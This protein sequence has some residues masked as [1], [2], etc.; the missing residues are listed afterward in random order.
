M[1]VVDRLRSATK[2]PIAL[3]MFDP[4]QAIGQLS[5]WPRRLIA[6]VAGI[7]SVFALAPFFFWPILFATFPVLVWLIDSTSLKGSTKQNLA[8]SKN[9]RIRS[10]RHSSFAAAAGVGWWFAFGYFAAG[11]FWIGEAF[12]VDADKFAWALPFAVSLMPAG[13]ALFWAAAVGL[14]AAISW[15]YAMPLAPIRVLTLALSLSGFEWLRGHILT[16]FPWNLPG[17]A[18]TYPLPL[19]QS[20]SVFGVYGLT[21][22]ALIVFAGP[23]VIWFQRQPRAISPCEPAL[24]Q[25]H[26]SGLASNRRS[27]WQ[28]P[29]FAAFALAIAPISAM[30][31]YG[32]WRLSSPMTTAVAGV[33]LRI[34]QPSIDQRKKWLPEFQSAI[35]AKHLQL[36]RSNANGQV[37]DLKDTT[38]LIWPEAAMPFLPL[39]H[40]EALREIAKLLPTGS[41][42]LSG[43]LRSEA[44][45]TAPQHRATATRQQTKRKL[46]N[47]IL[48]F[49]SNGATV[50]QYDKTHLVPFGEYL[51]FQNWLEAIGLQQLDQTLGG[52]ASGSEPRPLFAIP[53]LPTMGPLICY[54]A[55]FPG[56]GTK[57]AGRPSAL[58]NVT[59]D[60]WFGNT[61]GPR[62]HLQQARVRAVEEGLPLIRAANNGISAI[63]DPMGRI[64]KRLNLNEVGVIDG[65]LPAA[66]PVPAYGQMGD[67]L[68]LLMWLIGTIA[69]LRSQYRFGL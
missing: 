7:L 40:P 9:K 36:S 61:T 38:L 69:V 35:F 48:V 20:A 18:L 44:P 25:P 52:F 34:V 32:W 24:D 33:S 21:L 28:R 58:I 68:F 43:A 17:Y 8:G 54:E 30:A 15:R 19:M 49:D 66:M 23:A 14:A 5:G 65:R 37:D 63:I 12:L 13:L 45:T 22:I 46:F 55:I 3:T 53:G 11:L 4:A 16:G 59:N 67:R 64:L 6:L 47:S 41:Y 31:A 56:V 57:F 39:R 1:T 62:Q 10:L 29:A 51:P 60:G 2:R 26:Q 50:A 27:S 42:L